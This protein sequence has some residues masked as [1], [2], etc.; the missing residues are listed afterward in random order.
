MARTRNDV[1]VEILAQDLRE[2]VLHIRPHFGIQAG[3]I[4]LLGHSMGVNVIWRY[5]ELFGENDINRYIFVDQPPAI[6]RTKCNSSGYLEEWTVHSPAM[7]YVL[8]ALALLKNVLILPFI[9]LVK[10]RLLDADMLSFLYACKSKLLLDTVF[11]DNVITCRL[12]NMIH[13]CLIYGG[14]A[15]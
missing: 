7:T 1:S 6:S 11:T 2:L 3:K 15:S 4:N 14:E 8:S 9:Q 10:P 13:P 12:S 5:V